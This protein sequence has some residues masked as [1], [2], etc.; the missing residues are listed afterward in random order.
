MNPRPDYG[1]ESCRGSGRLTGEA[2]VIAG[3][4]SVAFARVAA[5]VFIAYPD[6]HDA[7]ENARWVEQA[8]RK[9]DVLVSDAAQQMTHDKLEDTS[10]EERDRTQAV[11]LSAFFYLTKAAQLLAG[12]GIRA[13]SVAP[14]PVWT[15]LIPS[16]MRAEHV[17]EFGSSSSLG[18]RRPG[19]RHRRQAR[20][21]RTPALA[22]GKDP[23]WQ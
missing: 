21:L 17:A 2:A 7:R 20:P 11:N 14:G 18:S 23:L 22:T 1:E 19:R 9:A 13:D 4:D 6:E 5:D 16:T 10:D 12:R 15:P 3:A 8:G